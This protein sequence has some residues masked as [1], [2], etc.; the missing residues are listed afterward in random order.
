[1]KRKKEKGEAHLLTSPPTDVFMCRI[2]VSVR[3]RNRESKTVKE[4][5][6]HFPHIG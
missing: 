4:R 6:E 2:R 3:V 5:V 1:M